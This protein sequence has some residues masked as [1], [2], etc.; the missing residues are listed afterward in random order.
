MRHFSV[1]AV[2]VAAAAVIGCGS[3][4][5]IPD[6]VPERKQDTGP[7]PDP[8]G[9]AAETSDPEAKAVLDRAV[10]TITEAVPGGLARAK[11]SAATMTGRVYLQ[12]GEAATPA[13]RLMEAVWPDRGY[14]ELDLGKVKMTYRFRHPNGW[15]TA[16][17]VVHDHNPTDVGEVVRNDFLV[18]PW[19]VLGL[20][21]A[22]ER[23]VAFGKESKPGATSV[24]VA[25]PDLPL[26]PV[27][28]VT[29]DGKTGVPVRVEYHPL[30]WGQR[31]HKVLEMEG[32]KPFVGFLLPER[33]KL[34]QN[35]QPAEEWTIKEWQFPD[36]LDESRFEQPKR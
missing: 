16:G 13:T 27:F 18:Q 22:D 7:P 31:V 25:R 6:Q 11:I 29:F 24:K 10:K 9:P 14:A 33:T 32:H 3:A 8:L 4:K 19:L 35:G 30:E 36:K 23:V 28:L 34:T 15:S 12:R 5:E 26:A 2:A 17:L 21:L 20:T 1:W